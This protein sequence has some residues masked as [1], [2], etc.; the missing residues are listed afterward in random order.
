MP[1]NL[2]LATKVMELTNE[3]MVDPDCSAMWRGFIGTEDWKVV[4]N[5][6]PD[7]EAYYIKCMRRD[8]NNGTQN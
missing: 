2:D 7:K 8:L 4:V 5:Y 3:A 6:D 1:V